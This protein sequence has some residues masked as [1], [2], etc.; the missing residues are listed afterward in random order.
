LT[1]RWEIAPERF[2]AAA[3]LTCGQVFR[4]VSPRPG[5][6]LGTDDGVAFA[7]T[8][9]G[10]GVWEVDSTGDPARLW[11]AL[12]L[13]RDPVLPDLDAEA[14]WLAP[15]AAQTQG[16]RLMRP[17]DPV[18]TLFAFMCTANNHLRRIVP[19]VHALAAYGPIL[20]EWDGV[21]VRGFPDLEIVAGLDEADLRAQGFGYRGGTI[22]RAARAVLDRGGRDWLLGL[23]E[24]PWSEARAALMELPGVGPKL[25]DCIALFGL[26]HGECVPVDTHVWQIATR[27]LFPEWAGLAVTERRYAAVGDWFRARFGKDAGWAHQRAFASH[28]WE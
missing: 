17:A 20:A 2:D 13:D 11:A 7:L 12:A 25:A 24:V 9:L 3:T 27:H 14:Q 21:A 8:E 19:M 4:W 1:V 18:E 10:T 15:C 22:P 28:L 26:H 23:R 16:L 6:W 5:R